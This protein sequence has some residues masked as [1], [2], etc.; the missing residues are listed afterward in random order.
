MGS[1]QRG[2]RTSLDLPS[3]RARILRDADAG[4]AERAIPAWRDPD[5]GK[6]SRP[7]SQAGRVLVRALRNRGNPHAAGRSCLVPMCLLSI[8]LRGSWRTLARPS[9]WV[10]WILIGG[11]AGAW[12][13]AFRGT[14]SAFIPSWDFTRLAAPFYGLE[15][16]RSVG[17]GVAF[18]A[19]IGLC[20]TVCRSGATA[21]L[22][23]LVMAVLAFHVLFL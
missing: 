10:A 13:W 8:F 11:A 3:A 21:A 12:M 14:W 19:L 1:G 16:A 2:R 22:S 7:R 23:S 5:L 9:F 20:G 18:F 4:N 15:L 17:Y 6:L